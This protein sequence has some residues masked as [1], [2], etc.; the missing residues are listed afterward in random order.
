MSGYVLI[1]AGVA[2]FLI[3]TIRYGMRLTLADV[4]ADALIA[5]GWT[6]VPLLPM[7]VIFAVLTV[8]TAWLWWRRRKRKG[9]LAAM[10]AKS[11]A[12]IAAMTARMRECPARPVLRP[13]P[14]GT[15]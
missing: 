4:A 10:G 3:G 9:R 13:V 15:P 12:R 11:R 7:A 14:Q 1:Y 5:A 8:I 2:V 6:L